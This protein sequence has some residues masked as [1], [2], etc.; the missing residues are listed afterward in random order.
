MGSASDPNARIRED[1]AACG[2]MGRSELL[3]GIWLLG[4]DSNLEPFG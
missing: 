4:Q 1:S 3:E 2:E